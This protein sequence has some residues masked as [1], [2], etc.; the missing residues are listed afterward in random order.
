MGRILL[1]GVA[2][3][4]ITIQTLI[5][6]SNLYWHGLKNIFPIHIFFRSLESENPFLNNLCYFISMMIS[7]WIYGVIGYVI[8]RKA[9]KN[10]NK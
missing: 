10:T 5:V 6:L 4:F 7:M 1:Y 9:N 2:Y 8:L 3:V